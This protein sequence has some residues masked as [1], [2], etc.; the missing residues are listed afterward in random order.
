MKTPAK[1]RLFKRPGREDYYFEFTFRS[2]RYLRC[3]DTADAAE[4][5]RRAKA[6]YS[7][8]TEAIIREEFE[9]IDATKTR[10]VAVGTIAELIEAYKSGPSDASEGTRNNNCSSLCQIVPDTGTIRD[11]TPAAARKFFQEVN[12]KALA[13]K[14]QQRAASMRRTANAVWR[15]AKSLFTPKCLEYYRDQKLYQPN[16]SEF[17]AAGEAA[18]FS[19]RSVPKVDYNPPSDEIIAKTLT[20]WTELATTDRNLYLAIGH[21]LAF[22]LR[23]SEVAQVKW[24]WH[25]VRSDYPVIDSAAHVKAGTGWIRVRALDP[26]YSQMMAQVELNE[27]RGED[28]EYVITGCDTYRKDGLFRAVTEWLRKLGWETL[29]SNHALRA[30]VGGQVAMRYGIYEAQMYLR[31]SSVKVTEQNYSHFIQQFKPS[32]VKTIAGRWA[33]NRPTSKNPPDV[34]LDVGKRVQDGVSG[35]TTVPPFSTVSW[36]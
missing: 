30:Y 17:V 7:E 27:W 26:W 3:L 18:K 33:V 29:K 36:N 28:D 35:S 6:K 10:R 34:G 1:F 31:H 24:G 14:D 15:K 25:Q 2:R 16:M 20:A 23:I 22:G 21:E 32:D 11:L 8:I 9:R 13:E 19:G 4:C 12:T 5:Q